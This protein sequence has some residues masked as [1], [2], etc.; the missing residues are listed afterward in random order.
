MLTDLALWINAH[1]LSL[2]LTGLTLQFICWWAMTK[3][4]APLSAVIV[5]ANL[6]LVLVLVVD[7]VPFFLPQ[8]GDFLSALLTAAMLWLLWKENRLFLHQH[9]RNQQILKSRAM[10]VPTM[11]LLS[12]LFSSGKIENLDS[13]TPDARERSLILALQECLVLTHIFDKGGIWRL[14]NCDAPGQ[15]AENL[16]LQV[17]QTA[18]SE[19]PAETQVPVK[20][21]HLTFSYHDNGDVKDL[22]IAGGRLSHGH[23]QLQTSSS[24]DQAD[25]WALRN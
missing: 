7:V 23:L 2:L 11:N 19:K 16:L 14:M 20:T 18:R 22:A 25:Y 12:K 13:E 15:R 10:A 6:S 24:N 5:P 4:R 8:G 9:Q 1:S 3:R 21:Y 17:V